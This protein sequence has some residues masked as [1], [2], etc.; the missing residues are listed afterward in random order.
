MNKT[1]QYISSVIFGIAVFLFWH[2]LHPYA[3][4]FQEQNQLF[5]FTWDFFVERMSV[6]GGL[7][8]Y[9]AE[10]FTQFSYIPVLGEVLTALLF[11]A[12]QLSVALV[13]GRNEWYALSFVAP[14][15]LLVYM[16]DIYVMLSFLVALTFTVLL[17]AL[18]RRHPGLIW[19]GVATVLGYWLI[20]PAI[21]VFTLFAV[22]R[23]RNIKSLIIIALSV[24]VVVASRLTYLQQY[25]WKTVI[26]G[27]NYYRLPITVPV[28]QLI[29]AGVAALIPAFADLLPKPRR[30][31]DIS[32]GLLILAGGTVGCWMNYE[33][34]VVELIAYDQ[35]VR[36]ENWDG[37]LE[38]AEKYQPDSEL[39]AVS[40][41]LA[42]FMSGRGNELPKFKQFGTRGLILPNIRDFISNASSSEVF[43]RLGMIN[44]SLRYAFDTQESLINNRK[45]GRWMSR[46][47][48]CQMLNGRYDV[49]EK[50]LDILS[51]S[52]FYRKWAENQ[53][54]YLRN[55][56][57]IASNPIYAYLR[58]VRYQ[59]DFLYFYPEMD[60]MLAILYHQ[61]NNNVM[62]A[63]YYKAWAALKN[64]ETKDNETY[65][66][67]AHGN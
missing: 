29:I 6:S 52:L 10:F 1:F 17:C 5:L 51:H 66:G 46:M 36:H 47:A 37:I 60:K 12:F 9:I 26:F 40:I 8:D 22:I 33:K 64:N 13:I 44:E 45:S 35:M 19:A 21:F 55:D 23:E 34:D 50:Y 62:A 63:W 15:L 16:C 61:N 30:I 57:A 56:E 27:I 3:L 41:N 2:L 58:S 59:S 53:R 65:T 7:A 39:G 43:W 28:M 49:A 25:P 48:E 24:I 42:L 54:Q 18:Y 32:L 11:V 20:G 67:N 31:V 14:V 38:R 4:G